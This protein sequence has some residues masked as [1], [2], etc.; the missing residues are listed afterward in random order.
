MYDLLNGSN[1]RL[2][3]VRMPSST[4]GSISK[5]IF[6]MASDTS[7][8]LHDRT[9]CGGDPVPGIL[10]RRSLRRAGYWLENYITDDDND[11]G[12]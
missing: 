4:E 7:C 8:A 11:N 5:D 9:G 1:E 10:F 6:V 2:N 12:D 3:V